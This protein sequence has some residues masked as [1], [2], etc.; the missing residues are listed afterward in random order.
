[1]GFGLFD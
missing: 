1:M